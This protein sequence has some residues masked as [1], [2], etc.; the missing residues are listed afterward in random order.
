MRAL[1][2][3]GVGGKNSPMLGRLLRID[4]IVTDEVEVM[5]MSGGCDSEIQSMLS[6]SV[7]S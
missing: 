4:D 7:S 1:C 2:A 6:V 3:D 5:R